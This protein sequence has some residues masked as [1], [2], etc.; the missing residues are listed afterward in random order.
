MTLKAARFQ[1]WMAVA[2][3]VLS[4]GAGLAEAK[5]LVRV[6]IPSDDVLHDPL[7]VDADSIR[8]KN[9]VVSFTYVLDVPL[10][11][12]A[13]EPPR[14]R[15]NEFETVIDC[16]AQT[17]STGDAVVYSGPAATGDMIFGQVATA[18][19]KRPVKVDMRRYSTFGYL[20]RH[21]CER[22]RRGSKA[23]R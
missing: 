18:E 22:S 11:G 17:I 16:V 12:K 4:C 3:A 23:A 19:E 14:F 6:A 21:V 5:N 8:W 15:S 2:I 9:D 1:T 13:G 7:Y 10:L 20:Y